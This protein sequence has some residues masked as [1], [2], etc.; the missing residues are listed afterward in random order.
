MHCSCL[1]E[2]TELCDAVT[3]FLSLKEFRPLLASPPSDSVST[4]LSHPL[5]HHARIWF[6]GCEK[7]NQESCGIISASE[8]LSLPKACCHG[9][10]VLLC[11]RNYLTPDL[12]FKSVIFPPLGNAVHSHLQ[13]LGIQTLYYDPGVIPAFYFFILPYQRDVSKEEQITFY[14]Q[15]GNRSSVNTD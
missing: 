8:S 9:I 3:D 15:A 11:C 6:Q 13:V 4:E 7:S 5:L 12:S 2:K 14:K 1:V 10:S